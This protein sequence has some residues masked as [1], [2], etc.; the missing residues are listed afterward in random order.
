M[1]KILILSIIILSMFLLVA[2]EETNQLTVPNL[3]VSYRQALLD[4]SVVA[5]V[6]N[7]GED[8]YNVYASIEKVSTRYLV[9]DVLRRGESVEIGWLELGYGL[10]N[11]DLLQV[12][13]DTYVIPYEIS[14]VF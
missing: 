4:N 13:A 12:Y 8:L 1:K 5:V 9:A 6:T 7:N 10:Q 14:V 2:C 3:S 11:G